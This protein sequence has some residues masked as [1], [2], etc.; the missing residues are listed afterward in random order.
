VGKS[1]QKKDPFKSTF[2]SLFWEMV[3]PA[4][5][6]YTSLSGEVNTIS[7]IQYDLAG[8]FMYKFKCIIALFYSREFIFMR[9]FFESS[10]IEILRSKKQS[11][12]GGNRFISKSYHFWNMNRCI[13]FACRFLDP[14]WILRFIRN[15]F[16]IGL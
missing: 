15:R 8:S 2:F 6:K 12:T 11:G 16:V 4:K 5:R 13:R 1:T 9:K 7:Q 3:F 10:H 14:W